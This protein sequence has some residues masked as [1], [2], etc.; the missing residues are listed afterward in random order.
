MSN[1]EKLVVNN[2]YYGLFLMFWLLSLISFTWAIR[3]GLVEK[4]LVSYTLVIIDILLIVH[5]LWNI[6]KVS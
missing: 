5:N 3:L 1:F 2:L 4:G 6:K